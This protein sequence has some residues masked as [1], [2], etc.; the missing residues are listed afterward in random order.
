MVLRPG[1]LILL[2]CASG[3]SFT[4]AS[5]FE[6]CLSD[7]DCPE[8]R[9]CRE[10]YCVVNPVP[11]GCG[12]R[13]GAEATD[14]IL[15]GAALPI[16]VGSATDESEVQG[17]NAVRL[18][19]D[20]V[21]QRQGVAG[22]GF[23]LEV[24]DTGGDTERLK[25]QVAY[26]ADLGAIA[27][28]TSGSTATLTAAPI[29]V[30]RDVLL[31]SATATSPELT[32]YPD[33]NGGPVGLVWRTAPSDALQGRV[34]ATFIKEDASHASVQRVAVIYQDDP[35]G[36]GLSAVLLEQLQTKTAQGFLFKRGGDVS[37]AVSQAAAFDPDLT[38]VIAFPDD[39]RKIV[40]LA[41]SHPSLKLAGGNRWFFGD[42]AKDPSLLA[43]ETPS[44]LQLA[45][46]ASPAQGAGTEFNNFRGRFQS[47]HEVD[48]WL[49]SYTAHS[50]DAFYLIALA[51]SG[52]AGEDGTGALSG[53]RLAEALTRMSSGMTFRLTPDQLTGAKAALAA[54]QSI[55]VDGASGTL[56]FDPST[57]E[58]PSKIELWQI[59]NGEIVSRELRDP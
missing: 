3:C 49:F 31:M 12:Q 43:V 39:A 44:E 37:S 48:P 50:Y 18:A 15:V 53:S 23:A 29:L 56:Q 55:D 58:A 36:Q 32:A 1:A 8:A 35:Y 19:L 2:L 47:I 30:P 42:A 25:L 6:E 46:G 45:W 41:Q 54:G 57:G 27:V 16:T 51:A 52:A 21:N 22:R 11:E 5:G 34:I 7:A 9:V 28:M 4:T 14:A 26:L 10:G 13:Y 38:L 59:D 40:N 33:R 24:C 20:E 17:L